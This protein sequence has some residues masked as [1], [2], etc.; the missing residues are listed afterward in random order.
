MNYLK[1]WKNYNSFIEISDQGDVCS[2]GKLLTGETTKNGYVR[3]HPVIDG[4][5]KHL[6]VHRIVAEVFIPNPNNLPIVNHIDGNKQNNAVTNL[7][8]CTYSQNIDHA[9]KHNLRKLPTGEHNSQHKLSESDVA[10]IR[11][12][13]VKGKHCEFNSSGLAKKYGVDPSTILSVLKGK[14]WKKNGS[15]KYYAF[16]CWFKEAIVLKEKE[17]GVHLSQQRIANDL[18]VCRKTINEYM[19]SKAI[20]NSSQIWLRIADYFNVDV[21]WLLENAC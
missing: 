17:Q 15:D 6:L 5:Q 14:T 20:P 13:Y 19:N 21:R 11:R 8:W 1:K 7:E 16:S 4:K 10:E 12:S 18:G 3:V 9:Y 2:H